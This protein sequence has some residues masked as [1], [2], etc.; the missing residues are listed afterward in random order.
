MEEWQF[1]NLPG[2]GKPLNL[3]IN[4]HSNP[5]E[6]TLYRI[7]SK[8]GCTPKWVELNK[9]IRSN[10]SE[11]RLALKKATHTKGTNDDDPKW[12]QALEALKAQNCIINNKLLCIKCGSFG[13]FCGVL[14]VVVGSEVQVNALW[15][16]VIER[17]SRRLRILVFCGGISWNLGFH[18]N[19]NDWEL[20]IVASFLDE[21]TSFHHCIGK[22]DKMVWI[23]CVKGVLY[24]KTFYKA[25]NNP[26][27]TTPLT[28]PKKKI[29]IPKLPS[30]VVFFCL[31]V[32]LE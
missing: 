32:G 21:L 25:L 17:F 29:W 13:I 20:D 11:W 5:A 24:V 26:T 23:D 27:H 6:D 7:L 10:I 2:K 15:N 1:E 4:L 14:R 18:R 8:N 16:P 31:D 9:K 19:L 12:I 30:K 22:D 28:F 3:D